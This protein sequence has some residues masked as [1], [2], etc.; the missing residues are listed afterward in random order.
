[1]PNKFKAYRTFE[2]NGVVSSHFVDQ[3]ID[4]LDQGDVIDQDQVL[5]D[6]LQGCAVAQRHRQ[7][8]AQV[9]DQRRHRHG[10]HGRGVRPMRASS[11]ATR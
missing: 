11:R 8:H 4:E 3:S 6:Q 7:D 10:G 2:E 5:D 1:M 9:S